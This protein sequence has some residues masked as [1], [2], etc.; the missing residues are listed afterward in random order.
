[1]FH[2]LEL[3]RKWRLENNLPVGYG[4]LNK[5]KPIVAV[6]ADRPLEEDGPPK[7]D[8]FRKSIYAW[9]G[10]STDKFC[11]WDRWSARC[12]YGCRSLYLTVWQYANG[13][14]GQAPHFTPGE[15]W[16]HL[17]AS[18]PEL[19]KDIVHPPNFIPSVNPAYKEILRTLKENDP[20][21]ITIVAVGPLSNL[22]LAAEEDPE[23]F[24]RA[25]EVVIMGGN[26]DV[27]GNVCLLSSPLLWLQALIYGR[28]RQLGNSIMCSVH[29]LRHVS[30]LS[31][32]PVP[33]APCPYVSSINRIL[34]PSLV[35][36]T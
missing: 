22:A 21:T 8:N 33:L 1:M 7:A 20:D 27:E 5:Y 28:L 26:I 35:S 30:T 10:I 4:S 29:T 18:T 6:G 17:F 9:F 36:S 16:R 11:R 12:S 23:T 32:P 2:V 31:L 3:E 34:P 14:C 19:K 25:K 24:L 13:R 15:T